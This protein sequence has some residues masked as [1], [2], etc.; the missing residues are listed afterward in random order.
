MVERLQVTGDRAQALA[1]GGDLWATFCG[2]LATIYRVSQ[3]GLAEGGADVPDGEY[4]Y[5]GSALDE[6]RRFAGLS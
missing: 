4:R 3:C 5:E 1:F 6:A 2:G